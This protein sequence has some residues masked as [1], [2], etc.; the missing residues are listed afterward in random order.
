MKKVLILIISMILTLS[1]HFKCFA[2]DIKIYINN[3]EIKD[4]SIIENDGRNFISINALIDAIGGSVE[5]DKEKE[6]VYITYDGI[7]YALR[8]RTNGKSEFDNKPN[9]FTHL[10]CKVYE[11]SEYKLVQENN[12]K[13]SKYPSDFSVLIFED[14][15]YFD[16]KSGCAEGLMNIFDYI[17]EADNNEIRFNNFY[18]NKNFFAENISL[19]MT[20][21]EVNLIIP[22]ELKD[23]S[24]STNLETF[25]VEYYLKN[26]S[27][28]ELTFINKNNEDTLTSVKLLTSDG[29][30]VED[31]IK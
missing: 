6:C 17:C 13:I 7:T 26:N 8:H 1:I 30:F 12:I 21:E 24:I 11:N 31:I 2:S 29:M 27:K 22:Y 28:V 9:Y 4:E 20:F 10:I 3:S 15:A 18:L 23:Y 5:I 19:G 16:L 14:E 25:K